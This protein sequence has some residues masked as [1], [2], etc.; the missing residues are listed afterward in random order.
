M[1]GVKPIYF[2]GELI[3]FSLGKIKMM[4]F[5]NL[6]GKKLELSAFKDLPDLR[7]GDWYK[8]QYIETPRKTGMGVWKNL[9]YSVD[10]KRY[11]IDPMETPGEAIEAKEKAIENFKEYQV[12]EM[13]ECLKDAQVVTG[14]KNI[15][16]PAT[17]IIAQALFLKRT[18]HK[19]SYLSNEE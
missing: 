9:Y 1:D 16:D 12:T 11:I 15:D 5:K 4:T 19:L 13:N 2:E 6:E 7:A 3:T 14:A 10:E 17:V 8:L 18:R